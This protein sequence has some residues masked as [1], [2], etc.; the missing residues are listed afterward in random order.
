MLDVL[1][2]SYTE[3]N[4]K[5]HYVYKSHPSRTISYI[6]E[7]I[8]VIVFSVCSNAIPNRKLFALIPLAL[9]NVTK[10]VRRVAIMHTNEARNFNFGNIV[11]SYK[12]YV[13]N[14]KTLRHSL[15]KANWVHYNI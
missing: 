5:K 14:F 1:L 9:L 8:F 6:V 12:R 11:R 10:V 4:G 15:S 13:N 7:M 3:L 2:G